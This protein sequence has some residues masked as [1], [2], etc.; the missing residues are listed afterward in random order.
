MSLDNFIP[1]LVHAEMWKEREKKFVAIANCNRNYEGEIKKQGDRVKITGMGDIVIND[2]TKNNFD[3]GLNL[4]IPD[5][6]STWLYITEAKYYNVAIDSIDNKQSSVELNPELKR[7]AALAQNDVA[8]QFI[9]KKYADAA[10]TVTENALTSKNVAFTIANAI[11][12]LYENNVPTGEKI[13]LEVSPDVFMKIWLAKILQDTDNSQH[14][15][16]GYQ[17]KFMG[18]NVYMSNNIQKTGDVNHCLLRTTKAISYAEQYIET[19]V[20]DLGKDGF[21]QA[22]KGLMVYGA[23]TVYPK[24]LV[25]LDLKCAAES[26]A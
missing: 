7:K 25:R 20:Y 5:D 11:Q 19:K 23:K 10:N 6:Q 3:T 1:Q 2:Y 14:L 24:E 21:G 18:C 17:G 15:A 9:F 8:D 12:K 13:C 16:N 26:V 22:V 4:Q